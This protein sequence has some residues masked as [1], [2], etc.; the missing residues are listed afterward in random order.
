[1]ELQA[2]QDT[3][4]AAIKDLFRSR[5]L[6][7]N[8]AVAAVLGVSGKTLRR[9]GDAK[10][11]GWRPKGLGQAPHRMY[12]LSDVMSYLENAYRCP[13]T[14]QSEKAA[15]RKRRTTTSISFSNRSGG[16]GHNGSAARQG[17]RR[18]R[19]LKGSRTV[20]VSLPL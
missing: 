20:C 3:L 4:V 15:D 18:K 2:N 5:P 10:K 9:L 6:Q 19:V 16:P 11:I 12:A 17:R 7:S 14:S 13:S 1:M 8:S